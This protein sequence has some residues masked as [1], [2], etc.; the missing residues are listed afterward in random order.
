LPDRFSKWE[1]PVGFWIGESGLSVGF[2]T[3]KFPVGILT[4]EDELPVEFL[5]VEL[6]TGKKVDYQF[7]FQQEN[8]DLPVEFST[9]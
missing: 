2:S 1:L 3:G 8:V 7:N 6:S 4:G 5:T 9:G